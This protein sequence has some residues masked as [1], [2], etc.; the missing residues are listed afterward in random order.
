MPMLSN[1]ALELNNAS[2]ISTD[3]IQVVKDACVIRNI[4]TRED[5]ISCVKDLTST[6]KFESSLHLRNVV[7][8]VISTLQKAKHYSNF[9]SED[10]V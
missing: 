6:F 3:A 8:S 4:E 9:S 5:V 1:M 10:F 7:N 2:D